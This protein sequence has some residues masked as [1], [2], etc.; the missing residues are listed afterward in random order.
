MTIDPFADALIEQSQQTYM[1]TIEV[2]YQSAHD[3]VKE[4]PK[5]LCS[6]VQVSS[7]L[8]GRQLIVFAKQAADIENLR[9]IVHALDIRASLLK[10][11]L[12]VFLV[13]D[14]SLDEFLSGLMT[15]P[16]NYDNFSDYWKDLLFDMKKKG[17]VIVVASPH[18]SLSPGYPFEFSSNE[19]VITQ[20]NSRKEEKKQ[21]LLDL[22]L[23]THVQKNEKLLANIELIHSIKAPYQSSQ[24]GVKEKIVTTIGGHKGELLFIGEM[25][26]Y[27]SEKKS[28]Y[29]TW[30][31]LLPEWMRPN[32]HRKQDHHSKMMVCI[33]FE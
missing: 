14:R 6:R 33:C 25:S 8:D 28:G 29:W 13:Q 10:A 23:K 11:T 26:R 1:E 20:I 7:T 31:S 18:F 19:E 15:P 24:A 22:R 16:P 12:Y 17:E 32:F 9:K 4:L 21:L 27:A 5:K 3:I 2:Q 30:V